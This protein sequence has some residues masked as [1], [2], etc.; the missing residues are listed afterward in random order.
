MNAVNYKVLIHFICIRTNMITNV[1]IKG[2][3]RL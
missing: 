3:L 1:K 2:K